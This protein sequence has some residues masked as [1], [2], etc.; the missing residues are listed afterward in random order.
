MLSGNP[1]KSETESW[2][3]YPLPVRHYGLDDNIVRRSYTDHCKTSVRQGGRRL[4]VRPARAHIFTVLLRVSAFAGLRRSAVNAACPADRMMVSD[5]R[6]I[7]QDP[8]PL[9]KY[10]LAKRFENNYNKMKTNINDYK[11]VS[12]RYTACSWKRGKKIS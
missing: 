1:M 3:C 5:P 2:R 11:R 12:R 6:G 9:I 8:L 7:C 4:F 10:R